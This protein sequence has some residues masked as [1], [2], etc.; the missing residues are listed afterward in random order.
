M[1]RL[2]NALQV[3][4]IALCERELLAQPV[5]RDPP[6]QACPGPRDLDQA[7]EPPGD[8]D[9][10]REIAR[11][12]ERDDVARRDVL[13]DDRRDDDARLAGLGGDDRRE[14]RELIALRASAGA[15]S[16]PS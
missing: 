7:V 3:R 12:A 14:E 11:H 10:K 13:P 8:G 15:R 1:R 16:S 6:G 4:R 2:Q 9:G 5:E